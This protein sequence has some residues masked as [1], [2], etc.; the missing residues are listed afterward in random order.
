[1]HTLIT[2]ACLAFGT[3]AE[4]DAAEPRPRG[5]ISGVVH[6]TGGRAA[7]SVCVV[8]CDAA[9]G[10]PLDSATHRPFTDDASQRNE[11]FERVLLATT[12]EDGSFELS[13]PPGAYRLLAQSWEVTPTEVLGVNGVDVW[14]F[15]TT[16][17]IDLDDAETETVNLQP[18]GD[19]VLSVH[20]DSANNESLFLVSA[21]PTRADPILGFAGWTGPFIGQMLGGNRA[22]GGRTVFHGLAEGEVHV[23]VFSADNIP[24]FGAASVTLESG[25]PVEVDVPWVVTWSNGVHSPPPGLEA[26]TDSVAAMSK[27]EQ[28]ALISE[29]MRV[30]AIDPSL[31]PIAQM[32][33][34]GPALSRT[35]QL[36]TGEERPLGDVLAAVGYARLRQSF[37]ASGRTLNPYHPATVRPYEAPGETKP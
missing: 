24:G 6:T 22:P 14:L 5:S 37:Q 11:A 27:P 28:L 13:L 29:A 15:G 30:A 32:G 23:A 18:A 3:A 16:G 31:D 21:A 19:C 34:L 9:S 25:R 36:E 10:I 35:V 20:A 8:V 26:L 33:A 7:P 17:T 2:I 12:G 1:M 4:P